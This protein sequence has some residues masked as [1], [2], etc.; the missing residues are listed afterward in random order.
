MEGGPDWTN[1]LLIVTSDHS[2]SYMRNR[3]WLSAGDLPLQVAG[4]TA[5]GYGT[6]PVYPDDQVT[7]QSGSHTNELVT[8][9]ARGA[10]A[11]LFAKY[12][13]TWYAQDNTVDNTQIYEVML[14][15]AQEM[16]IGHII[17]FIGDG[18]NIEHE[19]AASRYLYGVDMG[20]AWHNWR[21][22]AD[23]WGGYAS[24]WDVST[25]NVYSGLQGQPAYDPGAF[26]P[27]LGY[28]PM[29]GGSAPYSA[30][31][32]FAE[33]K[34][35]PTSLF[36]ELDPG[37]M[38]TEPIT[39]TKTGSANVTWTA[40]ETPSASWLSA[41]PDSGTLAYD[42]SA[43]LE[44]TLDA[45]GLAAGFYRASLTLNN[46]YLDATVPTV[47]KTRATGAT[48]AASGAIQLSL[49]GSYRPGVEGASE[50]VTYDPANHYLY[51][52]NGAASALDVLSIADI[53]TVPTPTLVS[54]IDLSA[55]GAGPTSVDYH[56]GL[57]AVA[58]PA[59]TG[60]DD[61]VV[62][63]MQDSTVVTVTVGALPDMVIFTP[64]GSK[65]LVANEGEPS[66]DYTVDPAGTVSIIDVT[67]GIGDIG[68]ADVTTLGFTAFNAP[69]VIDPA[70]RIYGPNASVAQDLE[71][72]YIAVSPDS[73]SAWV[74]LQEN[75][76]LAVIDLQAMAV[77]DLVA[78][79]TKDWS[80]LGL[81]TSDRDSAINLTNWEVLG[82]FQPDG[83]AA[84]SADG[85]T[86]LVT[87]NEGDARDYDG[88]SEKARIKDLTLDPAR[89]PQAYAAAIQ[90]DAALGRLKTTTATDADDTNLYTFGGRSFS[91]WN[92]TT[93]ALVYDSGADLERI[94]AARTPDL[95]NANDGDPA[96]VDT[97]S[98]DKGP[99]AESVALGQIGGQTYAFIGLERSG[100]GVMVYDVTDPQAPVFVDYVPQAAGDISPEG[101]KFVPAGDSPTH[102][103]LLIMAHEATGSTSV[104]EISP[105]GAPMYFT[106]LP[107][108]LR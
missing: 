55:Y 104:Y 6:L 63:F 71:P 96:E 34:V 81:D 46:P 85:T 99:E 28:D 30:Q 79:G 27:L 67:G 107:I 8:L 19:I 84:Y 16:G 59:A 32:A 91:I 7:Y 37:A 106:F 35:S 21:N 29:R 14:E 4:G 102:K 17:L 22:L 72:E 57:I 77:T 73:T 18:M 47:L 90:A 42:G 88:Y 9:W 98:D 93:G 89:Y 76:A 49:L 31:P 5:G 1:T 103:A 44:V 36:V 20:L 39:V 24:T 51:V 94:T 10:G 87:A 105:S 83:I 45:S 56:D 95:F 86:Y 80:A 38:V 62:V 61:G 13:N 64:D 92:G 40:V 26:D 70:I 68:Q 41:T 66:D 52:T 82:L 108:V 69:A 15:A 25:Y 11:E 78:L 60:T 101:L 43:D 54:S 50:I 100:G 97:R 53:R 74:T 33:L 23:G 48:P 75:N 65:L 58:V 3:E 12:A 2:N